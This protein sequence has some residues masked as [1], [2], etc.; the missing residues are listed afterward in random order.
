MNFHSSRSLVSVPPYKASDH[1][2]TA[3]A[4]E[5]F[6][7]DRG[8]VC[9]GH[10]S[11]PPRTNI[12]CAKLAYIYPRPDPEVGREL[13]STRGVIKVYTLKIIQIPLRGCTI[14]FYRWKLSTILNYILFFYIFFYILNKIT[15]YFIRIFREKRS[16]FP[17]K[18]FSFQ[19]FITVGWRI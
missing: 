12:L 6:Q 4:Y 16:Y 17:R 1:V 14:S 5:S 3:H 15:L 9:L 7:R 19:S 10:L 2:I 18:I 8:S 11:A 13:R